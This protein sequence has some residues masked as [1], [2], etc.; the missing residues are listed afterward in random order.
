MNQHVLEVEQATPSFSKRVST[1]VPE[2]YRFLQVLKS[3]SG[4]K[5][6]L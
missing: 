3:A 1:Q 4:N 6:D 2:G 5:N